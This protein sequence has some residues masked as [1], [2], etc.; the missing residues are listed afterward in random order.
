[1][2]TDNERMVIREIQYDLPLSPRPFLEIAER[3]GLTEDEVLSTVDSLLERGLMRR[4]GAAVR[5]QHVGY[6]GN[7]MVVWNVPEERVDE[8]GTRLA[9]FPEVTH[10]YERE[11]QPG[12]P[13]N[14]YAMVHKHSQAECLEL[15]RRISAAIE[16]DDYLM[17]FSTREL[18]RASML[19]FLDD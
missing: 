15:V 2:L 18:K 9:A 11:P 8:V 1:M 4:F 3:T 13:Y 7:A 6:K 17:L 16:V 12:W 19:Y 14:V 10:C 5:H